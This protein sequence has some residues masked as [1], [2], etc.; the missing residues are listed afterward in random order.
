MYYVASMSWAMSADVNRDR[1]N[2]LA[3]TSSENLHLKSSN[4]FKSLHDL[5]DVY[6]RQIFYKISGKKVSYLK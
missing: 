1:F 5:L 6:F 3:S 2:L 4:A